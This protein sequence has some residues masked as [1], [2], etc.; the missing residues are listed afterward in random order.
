MAINF[1][2]WWLVAAYTLSSER[3]REALLKQ[4]E[5][6]MQLRVVLS[7]NINIKTHLAGIP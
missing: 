1:D 3:L 6:V 2:R 4:Q 7:M 5:L